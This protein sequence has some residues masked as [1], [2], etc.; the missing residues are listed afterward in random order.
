[1]IPC[2]LSFP[3]QTLDLSA[4]PLPPLF[5]MMG[6]QP[7]SQVFL[8]QQPHTFPK[9]LYKIFAEY[10]AEITVQWGSEFHQATSC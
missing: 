3:F 1:M 7:L 9:G 8:V 10:E 4:Q 6:L 2:Y 5:P